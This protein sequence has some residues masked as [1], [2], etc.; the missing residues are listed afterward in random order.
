MTDVPPRRAEG[1]HWLA[2]HILLHGGVFIGVVRAFRMASAL[3]ALMS[4][5][6]ILGGCASQSLRV[7]FSY[8][9]QSAAV[10]P[11]LPQIRFFADASPRQLASLSLFQPADGPREPTVLALSGGG[12]GGAF[13][14]GVLVGWTQSRSRPKF[15]LVSGVSTGALIAPF[16]F[17]GSDYDATLT[18]LFT[19][20]AASDLSKRRP[21]LELLGANSILD[22]EPFRRLIAKYATRELLAAIA[23]EHRRG[24]RLVVVTTNLDAQRAVVWNMGAIAARGTAQ[25][26]ALFREVL[27]ASASIPALYPP[28]LIQAQANGR[29]FAEMH[30]DGG[31]SMQFFAAPE[32]LIVATSN[33][34]SLK[35]A[36]AK[37]YVIA[38]N[39]LDPE[40]EFV[41]SSLLS[42]AF[43]SYST[44]VKTHARNS[45]N[46]T[47]AFTQRVGMEFY[48]A[49]IPVVGKGS[50]DSIRYDPANPFEA[51]YMRNLYALGYARGVRGQKGF[52]RQPPVG[53]QNEVWRAPIE[54]AHPTA[55]AERGGR[56]SVTADERSRV[57]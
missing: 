11:D 15:S 33:L 50:A 45:L 9:D 49:A 8:S 28:V 26:L 29:S 37:L 46:A 52:A 25:S 18:E 54:V 42:I 6:L 23:N 21:L 44:F 7:P 56:K 27:L 35:L 24:R 20:G 34:N 48:I 14:A 41:D 40:F 51:N 31:A 10:V 17:L 55:T 47:Y 19:G 57:D 2:R 43:R 3:P 13:G 32:A 39:L 1:L 12:S 36:N 16:A 53:L 5:C 38:N 22:P 30:V 4:G